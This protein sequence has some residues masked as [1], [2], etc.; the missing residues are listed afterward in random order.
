MA[1]S[2]QLA[3]AMRGWIAL[4]VLLVVCGVLL[5]A[6][7]ASP[8][9]TGDAATTDDLAMARGPG[10]HAPGPQVPNQGG[11][12][13]QHPNVFTIAWHDDTDMGGRLEAF[14]RDYLASDAFVQSMAE[15][16]VSEATSAG[17]IVL[18]DDAPATIDSGTLPALAD[19]IA[20]AHPATDALYAFVIPTSTQLL[21]PGTSETVCDTGGDGYHEETPSGFAFAVAIDCTHEFDARTFTLSHELVEASTDPHPDTAPAYV[22][23]HPPAEL[24]DLCLVPTHL[25]PGDGGTSYQVTRVY[26]NAVAQAGNADPCRPAPDGVAYFGAAVDP[27]TVPLTLDAQGN[28]ETD[29]A[30]DLFS[31]GDQPTVQWGILA[32]PGFTFT[33][34]HGVGAPGDVVSIHVTAVGAVRQI[35]DTPFEAS[36]GPDDNGNMTYWYGSLALK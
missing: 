29:F 28:G 25:P 6:C 27:D 7:G 23:Y 26:S 8:S 22:T 17:L 15:Y 4:R 12:I 10:A 24:A 9:R 19:T 33:P 32:V 16:G 21:Q 1:T 11:P 34:H 3:R 36:A 14:T 5:V 31:F 18:D 13:L 30:L 35:Y 2:L 20:A